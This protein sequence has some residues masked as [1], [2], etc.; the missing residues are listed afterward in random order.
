[1]GKSYTHVAERESV[2]IQN[3]RKN[4]VKWSLI[5]KI[6]GRGQ[7]AIASCLKKPRVEP[8]AKRS[9]GQPKKITLAL[10]MGHPETLDS[11]PACNNSAFYIPSACYSRPTGH[12]RQACY[13][14]PAWLQ[15]PS[16]L[17]PP[18]HRFWVP[19]S[20]IIGFPMRL[21]NLFGEAFRM[22]SQC[23]HSARTVPA[24]CPHSARTVPVGNYNYKRVFDR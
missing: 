2:L 4:G 8:I 14:R 10:H 13:S 19:F 18:S 12:R 22:L 9:V 1:M 7:G 11:R 6:T 20:Y 3:R 24:Q 23:P 16:L 5:R 17:P 21:R 15:L